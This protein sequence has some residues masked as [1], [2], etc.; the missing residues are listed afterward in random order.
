VEIVNFDSDK[1]QFEL[2]AGGNLVHLRI[3]WDP[4]YRYYQ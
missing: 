4:K 3:R 1:I 2:G